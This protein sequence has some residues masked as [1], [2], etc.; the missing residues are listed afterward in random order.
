V[1]LKD[2]ADTITCISVADDNSIV[3][4]HCDQSAIGAEGR[5][6]RPRPSEG[7]NLTADL[8]IPQPD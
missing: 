4:G 6:S 8:G 7:R 3:I 1:S 2:T 5:G